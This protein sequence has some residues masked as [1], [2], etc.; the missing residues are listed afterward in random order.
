MLGFRFGD[1]D[2]LSRPG[3]PLP[4]MTKL[5]YIPHLDG[6][7]AVAVIGVIGFHFELS[8]FSGGFLGVDVFLVLSGF[9]MT[10]NIFSALDQDTFRLS[11]FYICGA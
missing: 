11:T 9:L 2:S 6:I 8:G 7:R 5:E 4:D 1:L 3:V 10:R